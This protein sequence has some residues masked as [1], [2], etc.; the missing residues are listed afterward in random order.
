MGFKVVG[1]SYTEPCTRT[2]SPAGYMFGEVFVAHGESEI[3]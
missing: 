1:D 2:A 3:P